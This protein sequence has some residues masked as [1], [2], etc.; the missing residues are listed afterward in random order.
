MRNRLQRFVIILFILILYT[1]YKA[2]QL[3]P[4]APV[5]AALLVLPLFMVMIGWQF[6]YRSNPTLP[7]RPWFQA[8]AWIG[9]WLMGL[10]STFVILSLPI[11]L[12]HL[13]WHAQPE[14]L[15]FVPLP[16]A[17]VAAITGSLQV[18]WGPRVR[19]VQVPVANLPASLRGFKIAQI[20]DLHVGATIRRGYV[21]DVVRRTNSLHA[22]VIAVTGDLADGDAHVI[23]PHLRAF[24]DLNAAHGKFYVTGNHEYYWKAENWIAEVRRLGLQP[25][26]NEHRVITR[27]GG[28][29]LFA[30]ITDIAGGAFL[31]GHHPDLKKSLAGAQPS[32]IN[33]L[34]SHRPDPFEEAENLGFTLQLSG[35]THAGQFIPFNLLIPLVHKYYRGLNKHARLWLYV[36][37]GTG[38]WG[39]PNR[40]GI[41]AEITLL[42]LV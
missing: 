10:W 35:H 32:D 19:H 33:I 25:L 41:P 36:N 17:L 11:D 6:F 7:D 34:L 30:G 27:D 23:G 40:F 12:V 28:K 20:S 29:I 22:D 4:V 13:G 16:V 39:P 24:A 2:A 18:L 31:D 26:I 21:E 3:W 8:L 1:M 14:W 37:Q 42:T 15:A 38:Y 9:S 5:R